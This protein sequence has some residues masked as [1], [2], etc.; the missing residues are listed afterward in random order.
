MTNTKAI[1]KGLALRVLP[2]RML[3]I[4]KKVHYARMLESL[5]EDDERDF[6]IINHLV[7][8]GDWVVDIG[9]NIGVYTK[10][11]SELVG[12]EGRVYSVE[13]VPLTLDILVSNV[14]KLGFKN[15][16]TINCAISDFNGSVTM[17][18]PLYQSGGENFY[19]ARIVSENADNSLRRIRVQSR[20]IDSLFSDLDHHI[21]F[22]KCDAE[23]HELKCVKG[24][25]GIIKKSKPAWLIEISGDP[26]DP[27]SAAY[28]TFRL[29]NQEGYEAFWFDGE[30]LRKRSTGDG[31]VNYFFL[32]AKH[33]QALRERSFESRRVSIKN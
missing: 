7:S 33:L 16:E 24:A 31:S 26:D 2:D 25:S 17:E 19:E 8:P 11:L 15:V 13:P 20:T 18:V 29:L 5:S 1:L 22:I 32:S 23:D 9:A 14:R 27:G 28:Q 3:Q 21:S 6:R 12:A 10:Y 4:V 30:S